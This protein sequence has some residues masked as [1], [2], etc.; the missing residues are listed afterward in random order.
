MGL[1]KKLQPV[2][3]RCRSSKKSG[4][5]R[6]AVSVS[7][8]LSVVFKKKM[9]KAKDDFHLM[10]S[11]H[12]GARKED[13]VEFEEDYEDEYYKNDQKD[14]QV[15]KINSKPCCFFPDVN[16]LMLLG[17][18]RHSQHILLFARHSYQLYRNLPLVRWRTDIIQLDQRHTR[19]H[20][21]CHRYVGFVEIL[22]DVGKELS[23]FTH[24]DMVTDLLRLLRQNLKVQVNV[25]AKI[26]GLDDDLIYT[27]YYIDHKGY[28][29]RDKF[30]CQRYFRERLK[31]E[32]TAT[33]RTM[34]V[35]ALCSASK[36][37]TTPPPVEYWPEPS[38]DPSFWDDQLALEYEMETE[39]DVN[40]LF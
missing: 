37:T 7:R 4:V 34:S 33:R 35:T 31:A 27:L 9:Q 18:L 8:Q 15:A 10:L 38:R 3:V 2:S 24:K 21:H 23:P 40:P 32:A 12:H 25:F 30:K 29:D 13:E 6:G 11:T 14:R 28:A 26:S 36:T 39:L 17:Y 16:A 5:S 1:H 22:N 19:L 20:P